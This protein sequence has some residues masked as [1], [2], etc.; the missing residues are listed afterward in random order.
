MAHCWPQLRYM[1]N[2][3]VSSEFHR[4]QSFALLDQNDI[5]FHPQPPHFH[6]ICMHCES[7]IWN[8]FDSL[9]NINHFLAFIFLF[10]NLKMLD[11]ISKA[12]SFSILLLDFSYEW[13]QRI[14]FERE[15]NFAWHF[16][17]IE[18]WSLPNQMAIFFSSRI[19]FIIRALSRFAHFL[20]YSIYLVWTWR[21]KLM[22]SSPFRKSG[23]VRRIY[24]HWMA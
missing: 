15:K 16:I 23:S 9:D 19:Y 22:P 13:V 24:L 3:K 10:F 6:C 12:D 18:F 1:C 5:S 17:V 14:E 11:R 2:D 4:W 7:S 21:N 20:F 8:L